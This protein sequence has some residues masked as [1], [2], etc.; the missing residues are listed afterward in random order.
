[1]EVWF[2]PPIAPTIVDAKIILS[3]KVLILIRYD[4]SISGAA[5]CTVISSAQFSHLNPSITPG[6]HQW[7]GAAPL[8]SR[9]GV[10][11]IIGVYA[12]SS[13]ANKSSV[14][15]FIT[16]INSRVADASTCTMKYFSEASVLYMFLTLDIRGIK[17]IRLISNPI[18][19]PSHELEDTDTNTPLTKVVNNRILVEFLGIR[20]ESFTL[21]MGYEPISFFSLLFCF[22]FVFYILVYGAR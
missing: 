18:H 11:M 9:S 22:N 16:T 21:F 5:F 1:M 6:N 4:I 8:F 17:D 7:S 15:V 20:E 12:F 3:V 14:N 10:Q 19:A 2:N 13:R